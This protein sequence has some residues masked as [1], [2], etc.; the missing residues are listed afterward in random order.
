M[1][2]LLDAL[3]K[4]LDLLV[5]FDS[6]L[7]STVWV[8]VEVSVLSVIAAS[9]MGVPS[10]LLIGLSRFPGK[11]ALTIALNTAMGLPTVVVGLFVFAF[12]ARQGP[13]G[14]FGLLYT[15]V[16]MGLG[17]AILATPIVTALT[18]AAVEGADPGIRDTAI[19]LGA[20][21][22]RLLWTVMSERRAAVLAAVAAGFGRV[23]AEVGVSMML[24][25]NIKGYT[26]NIT[27]TIALQ[28][29]TG[30]FAMGLALGL[31]LLG[32]A[33]I[34]NLGVQLLRR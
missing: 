4:A 18:L 22:L 2:F 31:V 3:V 14:A 9:L 23:F 33:L 21:R 8:S 26:R 17:Q 1:D 16:A 15:P 30:E 5:S 7:L 28:E 10:G 11:R 34:V 20:G 27:T 13:F 6:E 29:S 25:G 12:I 19:A 24:G 32:V